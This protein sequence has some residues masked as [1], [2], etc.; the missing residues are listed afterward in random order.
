M[1]RLSARFLLSTGACLLALALLVQA[2]AAAL[3]PDFVRGMLFGLGGALCVASLVRARMPDPADCSTP[4]LRRRYMR[5]F[6]PAMTGYVVTLMASVWLL[7]QVQDP[8]LRAA[9]ALAPVPFVALVLRA[10]VRHIRDTDELQRRIEVEAVSIATALVSL[11]YFAA[12]LLQS[13]KVVDVPSSA[14]MIWVL[15][16]VC[17]VYGLAKAVIARRYA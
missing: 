13:A 7:K 2:F 8:A 11:G 4:A 6:I 12:G 10:V 3:V 14:A 16:L 17:L 5:E 1:D 15:P 9:I